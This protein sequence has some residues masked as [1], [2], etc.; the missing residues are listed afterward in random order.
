MKTFIAYFRSEKFKNRCNTILKYSGCEFL[1]SKFLPSFQVEK[2]PLSGP[3]WLFSL[4]LTAFGLSSQIFENKRDYLENRTNMLLIQLE[5]INPAI[6]GYALKSLDTITEI[7]LPMRPTL[8]DPVS[9]ISAIINVGGSADPEYKANVEAI[10]KAQTEFGNNTIVMFTNLDQVR[11]SHF[12][13]VAATFGP[14]SMDSSRFDRSRFEQ[15]S[16]GRTNM[17]GINLDSCDFFMSS[18]DRVS[19]IGG[20]IRSSQFNDVEVK[21]SNFSSSIFTDVD[22][23]DAKITSVD[24][25]KASFNDVKWN[26]AVLDSVDFSDV[27]MTKVE[28]LCEAKRI[29]MLKADNHVLSVLQNRCPQL[30]GS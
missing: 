5:S 12:K 8:W 30:L 1:L 27:S 19:M 14:I 28:A 15:A 23:S 20:K 18:F 3:I 13:A 29:F 6:R 26:K 16:F 9:I 24:F 7:R 4:Y 2:E 10:L 11:K 21:T 17:N 25:S 22:F